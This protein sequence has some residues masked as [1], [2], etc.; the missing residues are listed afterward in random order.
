MN[1]TKY[2]FVHLKV[3]VHFPLGSVQLPDPTALWLS[4]FSALCFSSSSCFSIVSMDTLH[5]SKRAWSLKRKKCEINSTLI[6]CFKETNRRTWC[7]LDRPAGL[8]FHDLVSVSLPSPRPEPV[9]QHHHGNARHSTQM[10]QR[11]PVPDIMT[12]GKWT[13]VGRQ[14]DLFLLSKLKKYELFY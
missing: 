9:R 4:A 5:W 1:K 8:C 10:W 11:W 14:K 2:I 7:G 3:L 12:W 6:H 13:N